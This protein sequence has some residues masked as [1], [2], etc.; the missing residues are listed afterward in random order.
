LFHPSQVGLAQALSVA[1]R[2]ALNFALRFAR[3]HPCFAGPTGGRS[4][5]RTE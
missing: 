1:L 3:T 5:R 4:K 2:L